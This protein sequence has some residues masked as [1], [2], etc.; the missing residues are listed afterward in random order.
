MG[1]AMPLRRSSKAGCVIVMF[2][3]FVFTSSSSFSV[4]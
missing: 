4:L 2:F 1:D 3:V